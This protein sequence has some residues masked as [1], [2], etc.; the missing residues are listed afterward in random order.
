MMPCRCAAP[1]SRADR[2]VKVLLKLCNGIRQ[3]WTYSDNIQGRL[4]VWIVSGSPAFL[5]VAGNP[6]CQ[7]ALL[8]CRSD[9]VEPVQPECPGRAGDVVLVKVGQ[10][11]SHNLPVLVVRVCNKRLPITKRLAS[12][13]HFRQKR[14]LFV[15]IL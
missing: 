8:L 3:G 4:A 5:P 15:R 6:A 2:F 14:D 12:F 11:C 10:R 1:V 7:F 13:V 9:D